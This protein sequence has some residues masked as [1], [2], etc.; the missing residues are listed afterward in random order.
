MWFSN[1]SFCFSMCVQ[2]FNFTHLYHTNCA[3]VATTTAKYNNFP[4]L[5]SWIYSLAKCSSVHLSISVFRLCLSLTISFPSCLCLFLSHTIFL[6]LSLSLSITL[7][8]LY[9]FV[10]SLSCAIKL[11]SI[12]SINLS[13]RY[14]I[15][16]SFFMFYFCSFILCLI[17]WFFVTMLCV[18]HVVRVIRCRITYFFSLQNKKIEKKVIEWVHHTWF[19]KQ[20]RFMIIVIISMSLPWPLSVSLFSSVC[21]W[22]SF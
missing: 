21:D 22:F 8:F 14:H 18:N 2:K 15:L 16:L 7:L 3:A 4:T 13:R 5:E 9:I 6:S 12:I 11:I 20:I 10:V 1:F 17:F 19:F